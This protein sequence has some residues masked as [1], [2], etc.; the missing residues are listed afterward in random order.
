M[1]LVGVMV[2]APDGLTWARWRRIAR[3]AERLGFASLRVSDHR[4]SGLDA[5][6]PSESLS[7]WPA[8][9]LAA[10]WT[11]GIQIGPMVSPM[12]FYVPAV[13]GRMARAVDEL[14]DGA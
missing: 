4:M 3:D 12:T 8:L 6:E 10:E 1:A 5:R 2:E 14:S 9:A 11:S 13:L 7:A